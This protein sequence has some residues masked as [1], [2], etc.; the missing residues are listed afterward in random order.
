MEPEP[1]REENCVWVT[2]DRPIMQPKLAVE[3]ERFP[4]RDESLRVEEGLSS[5]ISCHCLLGGAHIWNGNDPRPNL[6]DIGLAKEKAMA[7]HHSIAIALED[8]CMVLELGDHQLLSEPPARITEKQKSDGGVGKLA[9]STNSAPKSSEELA[10]TV[11]RCGRAGVHAE[12]RSMP[13]NIARRR[14]PAVWWLIARAV[15]AG[16]L[17]TPPLSAS[18]HSKT[19]PRPLSGTSPAAPRR[20]AAKVAPAAPRRLAAHAASP[21][22]A[23]VAELT[24]NGASS[25][26]VHAIGEVPDADAI[27]EGD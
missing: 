18:A 5:L 10:A 23:E 4:S 3:E 22:R 12:T 9:S 7:A 21:I 25:A 20:L 17:A 6:T 27:D 15:R 13:T 2:F 14:P 11:G 26:P 1:I 24:S 19:R 16:C 8:A